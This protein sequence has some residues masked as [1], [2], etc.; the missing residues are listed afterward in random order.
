MGQLPPRISACLS[1]F[2][3][4]AT[5]ALI[6][7]GIL[8]LSSTPAQCNDKKIRRSSLKSM[9]VPR[10]LRTF[11]LKDFGSH[12]VKF[13]R[14]ASG[15]GVAA[16]FV[17]INSTREITCITAMSLTDG[18]VLWQRGTPNPKHF[19]TS[20]EIPVQVYDWNGDT[21]DDV[22]FFEN[23]NIVV[24]N[25]SDGST[26]ASVATPEPYSLF[27]Y[28]TTRFGGPAGLILHGRTFTSLLAPDLTPVWTYPNGFSHFPMSVDI[29]QDGDPE[30]LA[31]YLLFNS[32]G[33]VVWNREDLGAHN[34]ASDFADTNCDG[35]PEL[36]IATSKK[37]TLVTTTG[38]SM[39]RGVEF[40]AQHITVGDFIPGVCEKQIAVMDRDKE[41]SG[42]LR[43]YDNAGRI[44]WQ[45]GGHGNR[46]MMSR[47]DNWIAGIP[48]SLILVF[49]T[50]QAPP[51]LYDGQGRVVARLPFP[52]SF[53]KRKGKTFYSFYFA[54][55]FDFDSDGQEEIFVS[56][57]HSLWIYSNSLLGLSSETVKQ[58]QTLPNPRIFNSTFYI[59]GQ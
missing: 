10:V 12:V 50:P 54:Q 11:E 29:N 23:G 43:L 40:H 53:K 22:I 39:W 25:G 55:H 57:E 35:T 6:L 19:E 33:E 26:L 15:G 14:L 8:A 36:A 47:I 16:V 59:G 9:S 30:L 48:Q 18:S 44:L 32:L 3:R 51:T 20:G 45:R 31:G 56:N 27:I 24:S 4:G 42:I 1:L 17:Q 37:S 38:E 5:A 52:P 58:P 28:Q 34:D 21:I 41:K 46:A 2:I 7:L 13:G 49:R